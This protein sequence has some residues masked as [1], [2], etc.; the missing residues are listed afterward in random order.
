MKYAELFSSLIKNLDHLTVH[1]EKTE[2]TVQ[3]LRLNL[4]IIFFIFVYKYFCIQK[5]YVNSPIIESLLG[6][7]LGFRRI[8]VVNIR[9]LL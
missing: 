7:F 5:Y 8:G 6:F 9:V 1:F 2:L 4:T 3:I